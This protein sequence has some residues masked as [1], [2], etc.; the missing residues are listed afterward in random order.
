[1]VARSAVQFVWGDLGLSAYPK[2]IWSMTALCVSA[3]DIH[4]CDVS[5]VVMTRLGLCMVS[6]CCLTAFVI[7]LLT[8]MS[9][10]TIWLMCC[11]HMQWLLLWSWVRLVRRFL[12]RSSSWRCTCS[13][14]KSGP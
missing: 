7:A 14:P 10:C 1:M 6:G 4:V 5:D 8:V 11:A 9:L 12:A 13:Q 2:V 3:L